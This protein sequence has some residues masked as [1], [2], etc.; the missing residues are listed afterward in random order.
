MVKES[1]VDISKAKY[2]LDWK[3]RESVRE[4]VL[5]GLSRADNQPNREINLILV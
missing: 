3:V 2:V 5:E 1:G 4:T